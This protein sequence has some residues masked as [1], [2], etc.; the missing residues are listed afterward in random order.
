MTPQKNKALGDARF[1]PPLARSG[2]RVV[3]TGASGQLGSY[4]LDH[5]KKDPSVSSEAWIRVRYHD[6]PA[7]P[8][9][10]PKA[11]TEWVGDPNQPITWVFCHGLTQ[12][13]AP[14]EALE[15]SNYWTLRRAVESSPRDPITGKILDRFLSV[16]TILE[17]FEDV[18]AHQNYVRSKAL[19]TQWLRETPPKGWDPTHWVHLQLHTLYSP[20]VIQSEHRM[21]FAQMIDAIQKDQP[22]LMS[23]GEQLREYHHASD[24]AL[25]MLEVLKDPHWSNLPQ[26]WYENG[27]VAS[28]RHF[29]YSHGRP[30]SLADL[31]EHVMKSCGK[32]QLLKLGALGRAPYENFSR[33]FSRVRAPFL[34]DREVKAGLAE[35]ATAI[36]NPSLSSLK[37]PFYFEKK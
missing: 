19:W 22:F 27:Q 24:V 28:H 3:L 30:L 14:R 15:E 5:Q 36:L 13:S 16:G 31:A 1:S 8:G 12:P 10:Y 4:L 35:V 20:R 26:R 25:G 23:T 6:L 32:L 11:R 18:V 37:A 2:H 21:F 9:D 34:F 33:T 17:N 29:T 7:N